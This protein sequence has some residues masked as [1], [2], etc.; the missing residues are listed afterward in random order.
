MFLAAAQNW[1]TLLSGVPPEMHGRMGNDKLFDESAVDT[2]LKQ[3]ARY[4]VRRGISGF[5]D[6][7]RIVR[8]SLEVW[9]TARAC[10]HLTVFWLAAA[11]WR[12]HDS[13]ARDC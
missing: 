10:R 12:R 1:I 7:S 13:A 8:S 3:S 6:L 9:Q 2:V 4:N 5:E 11:D